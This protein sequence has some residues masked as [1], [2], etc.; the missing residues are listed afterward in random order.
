MSPAPASLVVQEKPRF[1]AVADA[2]ATQIGAGDL[3]PGAQLL[4]EREL[5]KRFE[6]SRVTLR[7]ALATLRDR[8]L[9]EADAARGW[10][11]SGPTLGEPNALMGFSEMAAQRGLVATADILRAETRAATLDEAE[12]LRIAP[13]AA[14]FSLERVRRLDGAPIAIEHSRVPLRCAP[15]LPEADLA[16]G[17][18][19]EALRRAGHAPERADYTLQAAA[20]DAAQAARLEVEPG[21]P[22]LMASALT[23]DVTGAPVELSLSVFRGD[24]YRFRTT[25]VRAAARGGAGR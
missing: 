24:R 17:S 5:C 19:Y 14:L 3:A 10:F 25:L 13:G 21:F 16:R 11:V 1:M 12:A 23:V 2:L 6:V 9:I 15:D 20:A 8:G 22:L 4:P 18:L 7:R